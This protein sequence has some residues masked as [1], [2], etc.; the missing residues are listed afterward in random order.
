MLIVTSD[1]VTVLK[2]AKASMGAPTEAGIR[3]IGG[4]AANHSS[5]DV[6]T[7]GFAISDDPA[8]DDKEFEQDGLRFFL[9]PQLAD[10]LDGQVL[11]V[12]QTDDGPAMVLR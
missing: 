8:L 4:R 9:E 3:I 2:A 11:D 1:A 10:T 5:N 6:L 7:V 12:E